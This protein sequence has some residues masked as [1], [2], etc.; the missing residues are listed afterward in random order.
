M[1]H[2]CIMVSSKGLRKSCF[3]YQKCDLSTLKQNSCLYVKSDFIYEFS[4]RIHEITV[5]FVLVT[6]DS[7]YTIPFDLFPDQGSFIRFIENKRIKKWFVQ[8][9]VYIHEK[10]ILMPIGLD[11]H[12]FNETYP[13]EQENT[14]LGIEKVD[15]ELKIYSNCHFATNTRYGKDRLDAIHNIPKELL[16]LEQNYIPRVES[17]KNQSK[18]RFCLSPHGNGLDCH[19]TWEA[20]VIGTIPIVK[21]SPLDRLYEN[22]PVLIVKEWSDVTISLLEETHLQFQ[23]RTFQLEKLTLNYWSE[24]MK[25]ST[26]YVVCHSGLGDHL[27]MI[28]GIRFLAQYYETIHLFCNEQYCKQIQS[29]YQNSSIRLIPFTFLNLEEERLKLKAML[30]QVTDDVLVCGLWKSF[31]PSRITHT[32]FLEYNPPACSYSMDVCSIPTS[33]YHFIEDFYKDMRLTLSH[34]YEGFILE[35][36]PE[37]IELYER[38]K[39]YYIVFI[40]QKSSDGYVLSLECL[41]QKYLWKENTLLVSNDTNV[42]EGILGLE[43]KFNLVAPF[44][45]N[46][47]L[48]YKDTIQN[49]NE[50]HMIDSCFLGMIIPYYKMKKLKATIIEITIR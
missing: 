42:Y 36:I 41:L 49:C 45:K 23:T 2:Q 27:F 46:D 18:Y 39:D 14:L 7:D 30:S 28:G 21:T 38:I 10:I 17:W 31:F 12:T 19:R 24:K 26:L 43:D 33:K 15:T 11:Y 47:I 13:L 48:L 4:K 1:E 22:L 50:I 37:S 25:K 20:L 5:S 8:N 40:Q 6:G 16:V 44:V 35:S 29:F 3:D 32:K 9:C 34:F